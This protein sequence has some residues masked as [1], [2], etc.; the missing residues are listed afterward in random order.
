MLTLCPRHSIILSLSSKT[1]PVSKMS[2]YHFSVLPRLPQGFWG[3]LSHVWASSALQGCFHGSFWE[4]IY[5]RQ[6][7][8]HSS[9]MECVLPRQVSL[10][11]VPS[12]TSPPKISNTVLNVPRC[13]WAESSSPHAVPC[14]NTQSVGFC[15]YAVRQLAGYQNVKCLL[16]VSQ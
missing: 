7:S 9:F 13:F 1:H 15:F 2:H 10:H 8:V 11:I 3:H 6:V 14:I 4:C 16:A 5:L 12:W